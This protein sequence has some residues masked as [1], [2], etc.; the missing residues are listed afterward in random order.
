M[1][2]LRDK[3]R[4]PTHPGEIL[5][6]DVLPHLGLT[7]TEFARRL[8]VSRQTVSELL[9]ECRPL[10]PDMAARLSRLVGGTPSGWLRMQQAVDLWDVEHRD[11][12]RYVGIRKIEAP[13]EQGRHY[14]GAADSEPGKKAG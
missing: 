8:K 9:R 5:R 14:L 10:T 4:R 13:T 6:E 3:N 12:R 1:E 11:A 2:S 7:Q